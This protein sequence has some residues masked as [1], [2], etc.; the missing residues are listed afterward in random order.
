MK[1]VIMAII[2]VSFLFPNIVYAG[3]RC[4]IEG[5]SFN[6][7]PKGSDITYELT[8]FDCSFGPGCCGVCSL[9]YGDFKLGP[10]KRIP[11]EFSCTERGIL[12]ANLPCYMDANATKLFCIPINM[13]NYHK[14][15]IL[16]KVFFLPKDVNV[17]QFNKE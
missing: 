4:P 1:K 7:T 15:N 13:K 6:L 11:L 5:S 2:A 16:D 9:W 3:Q 17:I 12:I 14:V 10:V 8:D